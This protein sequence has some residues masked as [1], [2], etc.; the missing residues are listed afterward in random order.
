MFFSRCPFKKK[1]KVNLV[2]YNNF[3][4]LKF[5]F[6][7]APYN[8]FENR[9]LRFNRNSNYINSKFYFKLITSF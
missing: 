7:F 3:I 9:D 8:F 6:V 5:I 4:N 1:K 2:K